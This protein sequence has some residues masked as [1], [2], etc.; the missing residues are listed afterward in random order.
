MAQSI[1][2]RVNST[3]KLKKDEPTY[4]ITRDVAKKLLEARHKRKEFLFLN[5][6][7]INLERKKCYC[8]NGQT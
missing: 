7:S 5:R 3:K 6:F 4:E 2:S 8:G 1:Q